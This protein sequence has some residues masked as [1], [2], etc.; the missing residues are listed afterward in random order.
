MGRGR[1]D[2]GLAG[3]VAMMD[4][5]VMNDDIGDVLKRN[6]P[7]TGYVHVNATTI[8]GLIAVENE[9]LGEVDE[10]VGGEHDPE[11]LRLDDSIA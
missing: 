6:A 4:M 3:L 11:G 5:D 8:K 10:H 1:P 2:I 9:L 7:A